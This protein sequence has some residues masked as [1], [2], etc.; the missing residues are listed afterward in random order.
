MSVILVFLL[1]VIGF[2]LWWLAQQRVLSKPW[3]EVG[4]D[5]LGGPGDLGMPTEKIALGVF[6][7]VVGSLFA[8]FASAYFMR[9]EFVDWRPMPLPRIVWVNTGLLVLA[10][11][12]LQCARAALRRGD[13]ATVRL[14][15][16]AGLVATVAFLLGQLAAWRELTTSGFLLAG[17]PANSF[18]YML[19]ALHGLH[20][21][22]GLAV[23]A[24]V[25]PSAWTRDEVQKHQELDGIS[26]LKSPDRLPLRLELCATYWH[27]L[28]LVW[29]GLIVLF[30]G[31]AAQAVAICRAFLS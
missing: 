11:V 18:F 13:A 2:S 12:L 26:S 8:L 21:L 16:G 4:P 9:M 23:L 7:A 31:W 10:S 22:G 1:V 28:L 20:I 14:G 30:T 29:L 3:L 19:T 15:L 27:F 24:T 17:S 5:P 25:V 6:L